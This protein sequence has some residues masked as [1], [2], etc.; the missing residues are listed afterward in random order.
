MSARG[1]IHRRES[2]WIRFSGT[3]MN[4]SGKFRVAVVSPFL[5][6]RHGTERRVVE[7][8]SR[9]CDDFEI[10]VYSQEIDDL[11]LSKIH[12]H[13]IPKLPGPHLL[14]FLWWFAANHLWRSWGRRFRNLQYDIVLTPGPNCID[15]DVVSV[16]I[17]FAE[18]L[19]RVRPE[20]QFLRNP[21][22]FW[23]R[24][25]HRRLYYRLAIILERHVY[26]DPRPILI[27]IAHK[28]VADVERFYGPRRESPILYAG[29]D[30]EVFDPQRRLTLR[31]SSRKALGISDDRFVLLLVGND[32]HKKGIRVLF[33]AMKSLGERP[34]DL[35]VVGSED[36]APFRAMA[37]D[38]AV[39]QRV[40]FLPPR[41][42][43]E[44]YYAAA[45][46]YVGPSL[47]DAYAQPPAEAMACGLP[48]IVSSTAGVSEII[49]NGVDGLILDDAS[50]A[51][52][53]ASMI[54]RLYENPEVRECFGRKA[55]ETMRPFTWE[56]NA[57]KLTA[58]FQEVLRR[59]ARVADPVST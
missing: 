30:H 9:M 38:R 40:H 59:K 47:E 25:L 13:R 17:V 56:D 22:T 46:V 48:V 55:A 31:E 18:F 23:P 21:V 19:R 42:D 29:V 49:T 45:D 24:L 26:S 6:K 14:S 2:L 52:S 58:I 53:L 7:W 5:D 12:W 27:H 28:T 39:D 50:D 51:A 1:A 16:H 44:F 8:I 11:D 4:P 43:V 10:H 35:L 15:A 20:L 34:I 37:A 57:R 3:A 36:P 32:W 54:C 41:K 33:D